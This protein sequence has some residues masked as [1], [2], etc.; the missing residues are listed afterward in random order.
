VHICDLTTLYIDGGAGGVN[1]YLR[2]KAR[3]LA[4]LGGSAAHTVIVPAARTERRRLFG[5]AVHAIASPRLPGNRQHRL[6][7]NFQA[8]RDTLRKAA[9][10]VVEVDSSYLLG[11]VAAEALPGKRTLIAG[12]HHAHLPF[13]AARLGGRAGSAIARVSERLAWRYLAHCAR[14]LE[15]TFVP[16]LEILGALRARGFQGLEHLPLGVNLDLFQ[17]DGHARGHEQTVLY[18]GR[19]SEEKDLRI[20]FDAYQ[21]LAPRENGLRLVV[22]GDGP[23]R[24]LA[25]RF[26]RSRGDVALRGLCPYGPE[27]ARLYAEADVLAVPGRNETFGLAV[28]EALASGLP[29]VAA[30]RGGPVELIT[31]E[32]G[33]LARPGDPGDLAA[34]LA[35]VLGRGWDARGLRMHVERHYSWERTFGALLDGY[36]RAGAHAKPSTK[37]KRGRPEAIAPDPV[38][39][40][41]VASIDTGGVS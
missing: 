14:P 13:L 30:G 24:P 29:V 27:L 33:A 26:A 6:L 16:S 22:V 4:A 3:F 5:S 41:N 40:T 37:K 9:P 32:V 10:D 17:P 11:R 15:R 7:V 20:L 34:K 31:P 19:L 25:E 18:V 28:L 8:V 12:F 2:E 1:T 21:L 35:R 23:Q 38:A 39:T 36:A